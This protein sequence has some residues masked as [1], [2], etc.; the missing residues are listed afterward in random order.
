MKAQH[1]LLG[2]AA[3][4][5]AGYA[6]ARAV[7]ALHLLQNGEPSRDRDAAEYGALRR[8][9]MV[10]GLVRSLAGSAALAYGPIGARLERSVS[11]LPVWLRPAAYVAQVAALETLGELPIDFVEGYGVEKRYG[12]SEQTAASWLADHTKQS[13]IGGAVA[14]LLATALAAVLRK[15]PNSWP[16]ISSVGAFPL[17]LLANIAIPLY[18]LPLFNTY[19]PL[20]GPLEQRLRRLAARYGVGE[21]EILRMNMSKQ[22][23][24]ANAF[25][26][27][28]GN[29]HRIVVG[30]T[31]VE[32]FPEEEIEF[33]VAHELGH[34]VSKDTWRMIALSQAGVTVILFGTFLLERSSTNDTRK[35]ARISLWASLISQA[36]R[37]AISAF[38]RS[39][40]WAADRFALQTT[41]APLTGASAFRRLRDQNL[42][43]DEQPAWFEFMFSTHP[44]L[45]SRIEALEQ[46]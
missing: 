9:L 44:S 24:K 41:Q 17:L 31:L 36:L 30:D 32:H 15:F 10:S 4:L 12:L 27:G 43:E 33:V 18:I 38:S 3:G 13:A 46:A 25:V 16:Y 19:E 5:T 7:E 14:A 45:K 42:A 28:I 22:T 21:A 39:R 6:A 35:L 40:E 29:T 8:S 23:K 2:I 11:S 34:F 37:P 1:F 20:T 26:I